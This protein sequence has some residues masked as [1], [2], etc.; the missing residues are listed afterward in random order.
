VVSGL[1]EHLVEIGE[2]PPDWEVVPLRVEHAAVPS[3]DEELRRLRHDSLEMARRDREKAVVVPAGRHSRVDLLEPQRRLALEPLGDRRAELTALVE[4]ARSA[5]G[6]DRHS[7]AGEEVE[8]GAS[9]HDL[10]RSRRDIATQVVSC[11]SRQD[12][13]SHAVLQLGMAPEPER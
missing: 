4:R 13:L 7:A 2:V 12:R 8:P 10:L 6:A 11:G 5:L 3:L 9:E 1:L